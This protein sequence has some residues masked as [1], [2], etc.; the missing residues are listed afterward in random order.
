MK[1]VI[2]QN[3]NFTVLFLRCLC[4]TGLPVKKNCISYSSGV[5]GK[6]KTKVVASGEDFPAVH[7]GL[8]GGREGGGRESTRLSPHELLHI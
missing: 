8:E 5:C 6:S 2:F 4:L 3:R 1:E 7:S